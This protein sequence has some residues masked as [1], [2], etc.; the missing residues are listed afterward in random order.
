[1]NIGTWNLRRLRGKV[2]QEVILVNN[3]WK[4]HIV[5]LA[6]IKQKRVSIKLI[7]NYIH[8]FNN[9]T[10]HERA[11]KEVPSVKSQKRSVCC[12]S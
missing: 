11:K 4:R 2:E 1:M 7:I 9:V 5:I 3:N 10:K 8:I 6:I 12:D